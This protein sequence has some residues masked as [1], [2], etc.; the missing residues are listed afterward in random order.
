MNDN[1]RPTPLTESLRIKIIT[2]PTM[3]GGD[4]LVAVLNHART[5][6]RSLAERTEERDALKKAIS[7]GTRLDYVVRSYEAMASALI[8]ERDTAI[9][10]LAAFSSGYVDSKQHND[11]AKKLAAANAAIFEA[12]FG[13]FGEHQLGVQLH[14]KLLE[15]ERLNK[16]LTAA[17]KERDALKAKLATINHIAMSLFVRATSSEVTGEM[18]EI[19]RLSREDGK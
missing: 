15:I 17:L 9:A 13:A 11:M 5:L 14:S 6:E 12:K 18:A 19:G 3:D 1:E 2:D 10:N 4:R 16:D 7:E 8:A